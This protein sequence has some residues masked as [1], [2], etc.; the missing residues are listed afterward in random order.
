MVTHHNQWRCPRTRCG[1]LV[2]LSSASFSL[3]AP[4]SVFNS[5]FSFLP[6]RPLRE[7]DDDERDNKDVEEDDGDGDLGIDSFGFW[8]CEEFAQF[9]FIG[10]YIGPILP[11]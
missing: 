1:R 5:F 2:G 10:M 4:T 7:E 6:F 9:L 3:V 8:A 11:P